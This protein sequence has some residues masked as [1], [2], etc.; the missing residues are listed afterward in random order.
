MA[1]CY[2]HSN[3]AATRNCTDC[4]RSICFDCTFQEV[5]ASRVIRT[6]RNQRDMEY[7]YGFYCP[8][9]F[10]K[11]S[12]EKGYD[13]GPRGIYFRFNN[14]TTIL[15]NSILWS[16]FIGGLIVNIFFP[17]GYILW[18]GTVIAMI[19]LKLNTKKNYEWY[20]KAQELIGK[21]PAKKEVVKSPPKITKKSEKNICPNC[22]IK[23]PPGSKYCNECGNLL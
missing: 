20:L 12:K 14:S 10:I 11:L 17:I 22:G 1:K 21:K 15:G 13:R 9:C 8:H 7:D 19:A 6:Y 18:I 23:N 16:F 5:I 2:I 4:G 3:K